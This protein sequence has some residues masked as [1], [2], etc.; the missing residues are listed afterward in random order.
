MK[1]KD[2]WILDALAAGIY[3]VTTNGEVWRNNKGTPS[4]LVRTHLHPRTGYLAF[5]MS[6]HNQ[7]KS[8]LLHRLVAIQYLPNP[9]DLPTVNHKDGNKVNCAVSN[10]E[11]SSYSANERHAFTTG[12]KTALGASNN[13][14]K[15]NEAQVLAIRASA[16]GS[17]ETAAMHGVSQGTI[18][19][20]RSRVSWR[21]I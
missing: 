14:S 3:R 15:L 4:S 10:L 21:H 5:T 12:L 20:I 13:R 6:V 1:P 16:L 2:K 9:H 7:Q 11:W 19:D 17:R 8:V 18:N